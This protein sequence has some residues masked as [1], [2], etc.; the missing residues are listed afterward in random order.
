[1]RLIIHVPALQLRVSRRERP[2]HIFG[3]QMT[4]HESTVGPTVVRFE[5]KLH[6]GRS[7]GVID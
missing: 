1:M 2:A 7:F 6:L 4:I 3:F 5:G